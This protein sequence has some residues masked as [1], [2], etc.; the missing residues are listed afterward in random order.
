MPATATPA[1]VSDVFPTPQLEGIARERRE[2]RFDSDG[3]TLAGE[4]D[5]PEGDGPPPLVF[6]IHHSGPMPRDTYGYLA[7][8]LLKEGYAVFRFDK[9]GTG[10]S[11]GE[12]GCCESDDAL[13]AYRAAMQQTDVDRCSVFVVA[14]SIGTQYLADR[15]TDYAHAQPPRGV[16]LLSNL[17]AADRIGAIAAPVHIVV[18]DSEPNVDAVGR[19]A[20]E[21]HQALTAMESSYYVADDTEHTLFDIRLGTP[22]WSNPEWA[23]RYHRGA[24]QSLIDWLDGL[25]RESRDCLTPGMGMPGLRHLRSESGDRCAVDSIPL[26]EARS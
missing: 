9:R 4:L 22:D 6:V 23:R 3:V 1:G 5:L 7:E 18:S 26:L 10:L 14:Q 8:L 25:R 20:A 15:F 16:A 2:V 19:L 12:Y 17:L 24:M 11:E 21:A 13:A